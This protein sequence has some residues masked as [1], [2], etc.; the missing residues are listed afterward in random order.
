MR[1]P[2]QPNSCPNPATMNKTMNS[3]KML[4][5]CFML[6]KEIGSPLKRGLNIEP[7]RKAGARNRIEK[8]QYPNPT[9]QIKIRLSINFKPSFPSSSAVIIIP[10]METESTEANARLEGSTPCTT[11]YSVPVPS[12]N[13]KIKN[14]TNGYLYTKFNRSVFS[15][16][17]ISQYLRPKSGVTCLRFG[18]MLLNKSQNLRLSAGP[19]WYQVRYLQPF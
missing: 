16:V 7:R 18:F 19:R 3:V 12:V 13:A 5:A 8:S 17:I 4:K 1:K 9:R 11:R 10:A 15:F 14:D 2:V 6:L